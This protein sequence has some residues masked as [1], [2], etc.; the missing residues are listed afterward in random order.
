LKLPLPPHLNDNIIWKQLPLAHNLLHLQA[1]A[2]SSS[3]SSGSSRQYT[4]GMRGQTLEASRQTNGP[5]VHD[6]Q[7]IN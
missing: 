2:C 6:V 1:H 3:S 7:H 5:S 4:H